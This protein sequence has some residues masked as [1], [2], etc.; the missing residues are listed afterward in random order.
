MFLP[1]EILSC[2][3]TAENWTGMTKQAVCEQSVLILPIPQT[4]HKELLH[5]FHKHQ[6]WQQDEDQVD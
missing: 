1:N 4:I 2:S 5:D 3:W 6:A